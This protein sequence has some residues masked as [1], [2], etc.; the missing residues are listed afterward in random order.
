MNTKKNKKKGGFTLIELILYISLFVIVVGSISAIFTVM[1]ESRIRNLAIVE[2]TDQG[3]QILNAIENAINESE[4]IDLP[5]EG[6][7]GASLSLSSSNS[8]LNPIQFYVVNN[9]IVIQE[10]SGNSIK[11]NSSNT[12]IENLLFENLSY[13]GTNGTIKVSFT[14]KY[15][16]PDNRSVYNVSKIYNATYSL[17][18]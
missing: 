11:L 18:Q 13:A 3:I 2:V 7:N 12:T 6:G 5:L 4:G 17:R 15:N 8:L 16:N 9:Q 14:I 10:G 1:V